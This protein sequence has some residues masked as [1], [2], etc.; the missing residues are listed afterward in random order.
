M[1]STK[2]ERLWQW[3]CARGFAFTSYVATAIAAFAL[4]QQNPPVTD[5]DF[6]A[7]IIAVLM[8]ATLIAAGL[9]S[10][11]GVVYGLHPCSIAM[12]KLEIPSLRILAIIIGLHGLIDMYQGDVPSGAIQIALAG[13]LFHEMRAL[14]VLRKGAHGGHI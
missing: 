1:T 14:S 6:T 2:R 4:F 7:S 9:A 8:S 12:I 5:I 11:H 3:L 10:I 13:L